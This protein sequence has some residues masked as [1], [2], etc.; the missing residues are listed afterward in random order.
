MYD[1]VAAHLYYEAHKDERRAR[2][3]ANQ[4]QAKAYQ[5]EYKRTHCAYRMLHKAKERAKKLG[6]PFN[7]T[8]ADLVIPERCPVFDIP[9]TY[10]TGKRVDSTAT[11]DRLVPKL[12]YV[13]GNVAVI[14]WRANKIK[15]KHT[16]EE[17]RR[18]VQ[19]MSS[20]DI[21]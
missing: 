9:L 11:L 16:F 19:W 10:N 5:R 21:G 1:P 12:G 14:S 2:Y 3:L 6:I 8:L 20:F 15:Y 18:I 13:K 17:L 7:I 4:E